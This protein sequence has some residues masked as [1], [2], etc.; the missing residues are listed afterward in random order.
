MPLT[1]LADD[2]KAKLDELKRNIEALKKELEATKGSRDEVHKALEKTETSIG[3][4]N[5]KAEQ[6]K[7]E[8][9]SRKK[10]LNSLREERSELQLQKR[11]QQGNVAQYINAAYRLGQQDSLRLLL[12]QQEPARVSRNLKY[13]NYFIEARQ[14]KIKTYVDTIARINSIEPEIAFQ[15]TKISQNLNA[16]DSQK[17]QLDNAQVQ[18][19]QVLAKLDA[20]IVNQ[21]QRL[22]A[23]LEDRKQLERLL[24]RVINNVD[25]VKISSNSK[26]F[27]SLK[28][29]IPWPIQGKVLHTY[30]NRRVGDAL[31]WQGMLISSPAGTPVKAVHY[32]RVVFSDYLRGHGL[33]IIVDHGTGFMSLYAHN[34]S[35]YK[36]IGEWVNTGEVIASVGNSGG[37]KQS[38]L[39]FELRHKGRPTNPKHWL[40]RA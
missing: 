13:Y 34:Q 39:Y 18:R 31:K 21:D 1:S 40:K 28:G 35:L 2:Q 36:T 30:G 15:T 19:R 11:Q 3:E 10:K 25:D 8:L 37:Q 6:L 38:A 7:Q 33:L 5:R 20:N 14:Q 16:L 22:N 27:N 24:K 17:Q 12:N 9:D 29:A 26:A 4:L 32:G 23:L